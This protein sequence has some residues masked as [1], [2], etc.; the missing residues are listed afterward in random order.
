MCLSF[1]DQAVNYLL[2]LASPLILIMLLVVDDS[3]VSVRTQKLAPEGLACSPRDS[4]RCTA[5]LWQKGLA[6]Y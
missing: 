5:R 6:A 2:Q 4:W 3:N 1:C